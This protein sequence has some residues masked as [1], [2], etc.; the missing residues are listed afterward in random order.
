LYGR[1]VLFVYNTMPNYKIVPRVRDI[2]LGETC[3][4]RQRVRPDNLNDF[5][6]T[7]VLIVLEVYDVHAID[8]LRRKY[9]VK[10]CK[11]FKR[12]FYFRLLILDIGRLSQD[13]GTD[14][15]GRDCHLC[16]VR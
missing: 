8:K 11:I 13:T 14:C 3:E 2:S 7:Y 5:L 16:L 12:S 10:F 6:G 1:T 15:D 9:S 4:K